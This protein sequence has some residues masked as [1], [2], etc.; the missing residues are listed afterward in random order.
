MFIKSIVIITS[1]G[2]L[3]RHEQVS[4]GW[5]TNSDVDTEDL[6]DSL[7]EAND[8]LLEQVVR[9]LESSMGLWEQASIPEST[10]AVTHN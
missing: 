1:I 4:C 6:F 7:V 5:V 8:S 10:L 3:L 9:G 2:S